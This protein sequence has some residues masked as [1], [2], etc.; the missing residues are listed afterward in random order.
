LICA[1]PSKA[2]RNVA[3]TPTS[4][5]AASAFSLA[6]FCHYQQIANALPS[7]KSSQSSKSHYFFGHCA[8][9]SSLSSAAGRKGPGDNEKKSGF[10]A[11]VKLSNGN[12]S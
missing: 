12:L 9:K 8:P 2:G 4:T 1:N 11:I 7:S 5:A 10:I 3:A 6:R